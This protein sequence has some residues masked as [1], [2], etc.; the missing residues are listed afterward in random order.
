[1]PIPVDG[2]GNVDGTGGTEDRIVRIDALVCGGRAIAIHCR[3]AM[4][5]GLEPARIQSRWSLRRARA[6]YALGMAVSRAI[7]QSS[8][9]VTPLPLAELT[10]DDHGDGADDG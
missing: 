10:D 8:A 2:S 1:M 4:R 3:P 9:L 7:V 5:I 6:A